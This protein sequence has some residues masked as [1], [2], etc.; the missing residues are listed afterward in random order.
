[1][2]LSLC[3]SHLRRKAEMLYIHLP[4]QPRACHCFVNPELPPRKVGTQAKGR[5]PW[6]KASTAVGNLNFVMSQ[7]LFL[8]AGI[9]SDLPSFALDNSYI[10]SISGHQP[11]MISTPA[12]PTYL[13]VQFGGKK[14]GVS[15][16][17]FL[18]DLSTNRLARPG[19]LPERTELSCDLFRWKSRRETPDGGGTDEFWKHP[20]L[21]PRKAPTPL[22]GCKRSSLHCP[23]CRLLGGVITDGTL[24]NNGHSCGSAGTKGKKSLHFK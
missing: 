8:F 18:G 13:H 22:S 1:M 11:T 6:T 5:H 2:C 19:V 12:T 17:W 14:E 16:H 10:F 24:G 20:L 3:K 15:K 4:R 23:A 21:G 9:P 7:V